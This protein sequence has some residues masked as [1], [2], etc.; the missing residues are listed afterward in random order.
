[1]D[2]NVPI[3][4]SGHVFRQA[5]I[6]ESR[7]SGSEAQPA[8]LG[9]ARLVRVVRDGIAAGALRIPIEAPLEAE[10]DLVV[11]DGSNAPLEISGVTVVFGELPW[12]YFE[13]P[14]GPV[15][16]RYGN[17]SA[18]APKY[19]L[20]AV[21]DSVKIGEVPPATWGEPRRL[22]AAA[23]AA[24]V[25]PMP[26][27]GASLDPTIFRYQRD[28]P[29]GPAELVA[30]ELDAAAL[31]HSRGLSGRFT[32]VR[33]VDGS[34][35]QIPYL[36]ER[37]DEPLVIG[38]TLQR[39]QSQVPDLKTAQGR[40]VSLY[41]VTLPFAN[42][43][44]ATLVF[45]TSARVFQRTVQLGLEQ[46]ADRRQRDPWF[47]VTAST[48][49][50]HADQQTAAQPLALPVRE[51]SAT[52]W[53]VVI[54]EGDNSPLPVSAVRLLLPSY[55]LRFYRPAAAALRLV[56]GRND[57]APPQYDL[58]LLAPQVMGVAAHELSA[59]PE[60]AGAASTTPTLISAR[61]FWIFLSVAV[62]VL[63]ALI[64]RLLRN[65]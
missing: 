15:V 47:D 34:N 30:L 54:N 41:R 12:I 14:P 28:V 40:N 7:L 10:L 23:P 46:P 3:G 2:L 51:S 44:S 19:D 56:Y 26:E 16:A 29:A 49:W 17:P 53:L 37:R 57:L 48:T 36:I 25:A 20:E 58:A 33:V 18:I 55:R 63:L 62:L 9:A 60:T 61:A 21:R 32:D 45:E 31:A 1:V 11:E 13:A 22:E 39:V 38:L 4:A 50:T 64:V 27:T 6:F 42:L 59:A 52:D 65:P 8:R 43:P 35:R 5:A 24:A